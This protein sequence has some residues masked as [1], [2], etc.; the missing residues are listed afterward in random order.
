MKHLT[1]YVVSCLVISSLGS[2]LYAQVPPHKSA[3][4]T[5]TASLQ[6]WGAH[7]LQKAL[8]TAKVLSMESMGKF[9]QKKGKRTDFEGNVF[10]VYLE[11]GV[12][13]FFKPVSDQ[14]YGDA[15][16]EV[17]A[18]EASRHLGFPHIPPT[19]LRTIKGKRGS[20]QLY[21]ETEIDTVVPEHYK[22]VMKSVRR[23]EIENLRAFY[24]IFG[25]WDSGPHNMLLYM[26]N[27]VPHVIAIDNSGIRQR[28]HVTYGDLP[29]VRV[30]W[31]DAFKTN[32]WD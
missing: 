17:A 9:L 26:E 16:A 2:Q 10:L 3:T 28:Q 4:H 14:D 31:S 25:Q 24:F 15:C 8:K 23:K 18:Y 1:K 22:V 19:V 21:I 12:K 20:F 29:F 13:G 7:S 32:D 6:N 5:R 11:G 30:L 27:G